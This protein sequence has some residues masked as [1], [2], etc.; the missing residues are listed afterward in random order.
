VATH[1]VERPRLHDRLT[2]G[3]ESPVTLL[4]APAGWGKTLLAGSW[5]AAGAGG[6][7]S[8]WVSLDSADDDVHAFWRALAT[9]LLPLAGPA[10]TGGLR[11]VASGVIEA[12][13]LPGEFAAA[14]RAAGQPVVLVLDNLHEVTSPEVHAG[15]LRLAER[16]LPMLSLLVTTRR[17]PPWPLHRLR[18]A[19]LLTEVRAADLAFR[20]EEGA[21]LFGQLHLDLTAAQRDRLVERTEGWAAGLRLAALHLLDSADVET[22]VAGFTGDDHSVAGYLLSEVLDR[23]SPALVAFLEQVSGVDLVCADLADALTGRD[24]GA[25]VLAELAASHLFVQAVGRAGRWYRLH[26]LLVD[27]LRARPIPPKQRRD[28]HRRAAE[29][30]R[31]HAMPLEAVRSSVRGRLWPLAADLVGTHLVTLALRGD[32]RELQRLLAG[33]PRAVLLARPELAAGLA[34]ASLAQGAVPGLDAGAGAAGAGELP[35]RR[36]DRLRVLLDL[37]AGA[38]ARIVGDYDGAVAAYRRVPLDPGALSRLG[39]ADAELVSVNVLSN[40][41]TAE[42]WTG[43]LHR[44]ESHLLAAA[45]AGGAPPALPNV[46]AAAHLALLQCERG[47]LDAAEATALRTVAAAAAAGWESAAQ[48]ASAYLA[49][50]RVVFDRGGL[51]EA[52]SWLDRTADAE[53]LAREPHVLLGA[54]L[55]VAA[56]RQAAGDR[57]RALAGLRGTAD[58]LGSWAPPQALAERWLLAEAALLARSGDA[59]QSRALLERVGPPCTADGAI[60]TAR[61]HLLLGGAAEAGTAL[62]RG[63]A[64]TH[65]RA[66]VGAGVVGAL[67]ADATGEGERALVL[68][69]DALLAAAP[70]ALRRPFLAEADDLR[71]LLGRRVE[72]GSAVTAFAVDL[73]RRLSGT[74]VDDLAVRRALVDP[75]TERERTVLSYL[76]STLSN[77]EIATEL[78]V[79]VNTVKTH[80]RTVYRKLGAGGRRDAVRRARAMRLL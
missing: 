5:I 62:E 55:V 6:R 34:G 17:D 8:A 57:E 3:L 50:A 40:L 80:Q 41:G 38:R 52:D 2:A 13:Q 46:N 54:A 76:A 71:E 4:A 9:A 73:L 24:D 21:A 30:F 22:A 37:C 1:V 70:H 32:A 65:P 29:W 69:E 59:A 42:L 31:A 23:Q 44:A 66:R 74:P 39:L 68:L 7:A 11:R 56:R 19:G 10:T 27:I 53:V 64:G 18:L 33:V 51:G 75:L 15:L 67:V 79:S 49:L 48:V 16:P 58:L 77:A 63:P 35:G 78:Y 43:D 26:R 25:A 28:L 60:A 72:R 61:L 20:A 45:E 36:G 14:L 12:H 47:E